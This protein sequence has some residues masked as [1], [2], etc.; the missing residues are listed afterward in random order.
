MDK[1]LLL[2]VVALV[3]V[4]VWRGPKTLPQIGQMLGRGVKEARKEAAE[5][6]TDLHKD[7]ATAIPPP[8]SASPVAAVA[9]PVAP[10]LPPAQ[11]PATPDPGAPG[12][13]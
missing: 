7:D 4:I 8:P 5:I 6:K 9:Q 12:P 2:L 13:A 3:I 1:L 11:P 10:P